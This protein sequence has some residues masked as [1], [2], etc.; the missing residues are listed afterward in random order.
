MPVP[1]S[2]ATAQRLP[3]ARLPG[4]VGIAAG[5]LF[6]AM[7]IW[8]H[9][10]GLGPTQHTRPS[11]INQLGFALA[12]T[13]YSVLAWGLARARPAAAHRGAVAFPVVLAIAWTALATGNLL[14]LVTPLTPDAD[15]LNP[16]GGLG[17][18]LGLAGLGVT[19][20]LG[21]R[22]TGWRRYWPL[23]LACVY[24]FALLIP[25]FLGVAP[26]AIAETLWALGIS[27]LGLALATA[28]R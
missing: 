21:S 24:I 1:S 25:A 6:A 22:W 27:G 8:E 7:S 2:A 4:A 11:L 5:V 15:P 20:A 13:G 28:D 16:L 26:T 10:A 14:Q 17:Q 19:V 3:S 12:L 18:A 9:V 23:G